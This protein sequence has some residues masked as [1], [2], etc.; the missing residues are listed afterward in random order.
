MGNIL[1]QAVAH[2]WLQNHNDLFG[3]FCCIEF[4]IYSFV[5]LFLDTK[6]AISNVF[7]INY[8]DIA[9]LSDFALF[10]RWDPLH[11]R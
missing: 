10:Q 4:L 2:S 11:Q 7:T 9:A 6:S 3:Y 1:Q 5:F 8:K